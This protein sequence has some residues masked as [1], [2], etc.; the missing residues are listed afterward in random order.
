MTNFKKFFWGYTP[1]L[2]LKG[3]RRPESGK[4]AKGKERRGRGKRL[5]IEHFSLCTAVPK[6]SDFNNC[7]NWPY[8]NSGSPRHSSSTLSR[9][10]VLLCQQLCLSTNM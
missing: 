6:A 1:G 4:G 7:L 2:P 9:A 3:G 10:V 5:R 8:N